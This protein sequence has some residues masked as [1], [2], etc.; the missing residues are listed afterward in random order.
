M[1]PEV[2]RVTAALSEK[3]PYLATRGA[4]PG[5]GVAPGVLSF[6]APAALSSRTNK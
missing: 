2:V 3:A 4:T 1:T 5:V 6:Y